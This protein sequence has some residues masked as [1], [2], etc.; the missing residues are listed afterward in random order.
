[1]RTQN[2]ENKSLLRQNR[3]THFAL[4]AI[5][6][7]L[8]PAI[9]FGGTWAASG[10]ESFVRSS[11]DP[12]AVLRTFS[13]LNPN[14][15]Y[16]LRINNGGAKGEFARATGFVL[17][18]GVQMVGL[19]DLNQ[20]TFL[21]QKKVSLLLHD[22]L[23]IK[24]LSPPGSGITLEIVGVDD[25]LPSISGVISPSPNAAGWNDSNVTV[26]FKCSDKNSGVA[27]CPSPV[28]ITTEGANQV[29]QGIAI[30]KAGNR[31]TASI[32]VNLD[33]TPPMISGTINP[34]PDASGWNTG[35]V[36][37]NFTC[38]DSLSRVA[39]CPPPVAV[40]TEGANQLVTGTATDRAGNTATAKVT[41]NIS[42]H[43]FSVR[44]YGGKCLDYG[45][46]TRAR[47]ATV[48]LNDCAE[49]HPIRVE[50]I[51]DRHEVILHAG[52]SVIGIHNPPVVT[53]GGPPP[54]PQTE[55][56]LELQRYNPILATTANQ[57]FSL[58]GDSI[59]LA[60]TR[61]CI[62]ADGG[63]ACD[64]PPPHLV[65]QV[66]NARGASG[67]PLVVG[68][69]NLAD[70][71]FWDFNAIDGADK[72]PTSGFVRLGFPENPATTFYRLLNL[73]A[74]YGSPTPSHAGPGT[75]IKIAASTTIDLAALNALQIPS[76]VTIRGDRRGTLFGPL[77]CNGCVSKLPSAPGGQGAMLEIAGYE[78]R[79]TGLRLQGTSRNT[80]K[81]QS[82][83]TGVFSH[84]VFSHSIVDHNDISDWTDDGVLVVGTDT[85]EL[86][87]ACD[88]GEI[89]DPQTR[90]HSNF[91][92]RNFIHHNRMQDNGYGVD[93]EKGA[94]ALIEGNT[95]VSN[96]HAIASQGLAHSGYRAR[97]NLVLSDAPLQNPGS[98]PFCYY[99]HDFDL[100]FPF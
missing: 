63:A 6:M 77:L 74:P 68:L 12:I 25:D 51:N 62:N 69:R 76:G 14:T 31:A 53:L 11:G 37:V 34:P 93:S 41:A 28:T 35:K 80:D 33:K 56:A 92:A 8:F 16:T 18:N 39:K 2:S 98:C 58:D 89:N 60:S 9:T 79:I 4:V 99:T 15:T 45:T 55:F 64:T 46:A 42:F 17:L 47:S 22:R 90:L 43:F 78:V 88:P 24:L 61:P 87:S 26:S 83:S 100:E 75:V 82:G 94:Y 38:S 29:A 27:V 86:N 40:T 67:S 44:N 72:D 13:V 54:P 49:A 97:F 48:F 10:P 84:E 50:E 32:S 5:L 57:I 30:D 59:I 70:S 91:I 20:H 3:L 85:P 21:I 66:Q 81:G 36:T 65:I 7:A 95:F 1:M 52:A 71:E 23:T 73:I 96:R 19:N